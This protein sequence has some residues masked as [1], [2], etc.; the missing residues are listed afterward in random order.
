MSDA[1][2][3]HLSA[4]RQDVGRIIRGEDAGATSR[5]ERHVVVPVEPTPEMIDAAMVA[6]VPAFRRDQ[7]FA[8]WY[9]A[10]LSAA[11]PVQMEAVA[12]RPMETAPKNCTMVRLL[13]NYS[14]EHD[15]DNPLEDSAEPTA[16]IGFC[17]DDNVL[18]GE[19][20]GWQFAGWDWSQD[21]FTEGSGKPIAWAP[22]EGPLPGASPGPSSD[23]ANSEEFSMTDAQIKRMAERFLGW[24]L[25]ADFS[26]DAGISFDPIFN[27]GSPYEARH[28][29]TG[30]NLFNYDQAMAMVRHMIEGSAQASSERDAIIEMCAKVAAKAMHL[31]GTKPEHIA[32]AIRSLKSQ[33]E[34]GEGNP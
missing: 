22:Y 16:T 21:C 11:P 25:P 26:P 18:D 5:A 7:A 29:P 8:I 10:M 6:S 23:R 34:S 30:T 27:K 32:T 20:A 33:P 2:E 9:K 13:I 1:F 17:N 24:K 31:G 14:D 28:N 4:R 12:W 19:G 15:G 3:K